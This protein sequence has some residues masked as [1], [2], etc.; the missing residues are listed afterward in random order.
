M[1]GRKKK[2]A[3]MPPQR[4]KAAGRGVLWVI[5]VLFLSSGMLRLGEHGVAVAK[6][7]GVLAGKVVHDDNG[8]ETCETEEDI[9]QVLGLLREREIVLEERERNLESRLQVLKA[10]E[11]QIEKKMSALVDAEEALKSTMALADGAAERDL[12][13]L[14]QVYE[15][16][17]PKQAIPL[18]SQMD[19][20]FAAGFLGRMR[21][22]VAA[23]IMAGLDPQ[24][25]YAISV[26]LAGR[27]SN[28]PTN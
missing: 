19:P 4:K 11:E 26:I 10:A 23:Q 17:K 5:A 20:Q 16:M 25:S 28:V 3:S 14:T 1:F 2:A 15:N 22:E 8:G 27:N 13:Q 12:T 18:F 21:S 24:K 7:V 6:E 9:A